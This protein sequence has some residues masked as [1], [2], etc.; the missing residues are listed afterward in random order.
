MQEPNLGVLV[1][2]YIGPK[3]FAN[4]IAQFFNLAPTKVSLYLVNSDE[5]EEDPI[6][7]LKTKGN[8]TKRLIDYGVGE[9]SLIVIKQTDMNEP[10]SKIYNEIAKDCGISISRVKE[11]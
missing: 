8:C 11:C 5:R 7:E 3:V 1:S 6:I 2:A 9:G 10:T 4:Y